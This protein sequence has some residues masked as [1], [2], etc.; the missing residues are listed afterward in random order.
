LKAK[1]PFVARLSDE[2]I[3]QR[4]NGRR[5]PL[6]VPGQRRTSDLHMS[7]FVTYLAGEYNLIEPHVAGRAGPSMLAESL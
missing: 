2:Y 7:Y 1:P 3:N 5:L 6:L 4:M